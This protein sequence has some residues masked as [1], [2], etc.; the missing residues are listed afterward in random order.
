VTAVYFDSQMSDDALPEALWKRTSRQ[1]AA[2]HIKRDTRTQPKPEEPLELDPHIRVLPPPGAILRFSGAHLHSTIPSTS[3]RTRFSSDFRTVHID[4]VAAHR[5]APNIDSQ[6]AGT[7]MRDYLHGND[8]AHVP[9]NLVAMYDL[10]PMAQ[11][12]DAAA[13]ETPAHP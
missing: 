3:G 10:P 9:E 2:Q 7:T 11:T 5:G 8:L 4:D 12:T 6:W 13:A 1:T